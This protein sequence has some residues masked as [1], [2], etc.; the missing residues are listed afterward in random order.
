MEER[1][2]E[3]EDCQKA[4]F[5]KLVERLRV[6]IFDIEMPEK[7]D[8]TEYAFEYKITVGLVHLGNNDE[9]DIDDPDNEEGERKKNE[10][11]K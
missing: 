11:E 5:S 1:K 10:A 6:I 4:A 8:I 3:F 2:Q 9:S 7:H